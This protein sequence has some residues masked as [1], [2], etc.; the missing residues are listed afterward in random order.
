[1]EAPLPAHSRGLFFAQLEFGHWSIIFNKGVDCK[2]GSVSRSRGMV[3]IPLIIQVALGSYAAYPGFGRTIHA[4][5]GK[6]PLW[7]CIEWGLPS[8]RVA[9][10]LVSSYLAFSPLPL[11][12]RGG[13]FS[14][15]L[16]LGL[17]PVPVKNHSAL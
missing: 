6:H 5:F 10:E 4:P 11:V 9:T 17:P 12:I 8:S 15:A 3:I 2:P 13:M 1:M 14:V 7:P 16:S